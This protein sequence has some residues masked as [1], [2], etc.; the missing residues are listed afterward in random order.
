MRRRPLCFWHTCGAVSG[1]TKGTARARPTVWV[2]ADTLTWPQG[3]GNFWAYA[4]WALGLASNGCRVVWLERAGKDLGETELAVLRAAIE[5]K[6]ARYGLAGCL[7][8]YREGESLDG[9]VG[10]D[11]A[12]QAD[13]LVNI[14]YDAHAE[15]LDRFPRKA[16]LDIDPGLTQLWAIEGTC[17]IPAHDVYFTIGE[18]V[19]RPL[20][21]CGLTWE[22]T[23]PCVALDWW[24]VTPFP[25]E[26]PFTTVT[27]WGNPEWFVDAGT[28]HN[29]NKRSGFQRY[30]GLPARVA[31]PLELALCMEADEDLRLAPSEQD[32]VLALE[33]LGWHVRHSYEV[34]STPWDYQRYIQASRG[35]FGAAKAAYRLLANAWVSDR[36]ICYLASGRPAVVEHTGP[37]AFLPER[38]GLFRFRDADEAVECLDAVAADWAAESHLARALAEE[39]FDARIVTARVLERALGHSAALT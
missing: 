22:Y 32:E 38:A 4:N 23:P 30:L 28:V 13:L 20:P 18:T 19:G 33:R 14:A 12:G 6:L 5:E 27:N 11:Q 35:E 25:A 26:A 1:G 7:A 15:V 17:P 31:A 36:T 34:S 39:H 3:G 10:L 8:L 29:N 37:S 21:D 2:G 16:M 9:T 24:P